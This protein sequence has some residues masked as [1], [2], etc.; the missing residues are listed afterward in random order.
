MYL[1]ARFHMMQL[2]LSFDKHMESRLQLS[3][4]ELCIWSTQ[5]DMKVNRSKTKEIMIDFSAQNSVAEIPLLTIQDEPIERITHAT[6]VCVT[7]SSDLTWNAHVN[8]IL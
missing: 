4:D 7:V 2:I 8:T 1:K 6:V 5:N 3:L